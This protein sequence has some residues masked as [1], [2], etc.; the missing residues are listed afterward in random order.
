MGTRCRESYL[1]VYCIGGVL[2]LTHTLLPED[3][4]A[5]A[6]RFQQLSQFLPEVLADFQVELVQHPEAG[7]AVA[8][9]YGFLVAAAWVSSAIYMALLVKLSS[10]AKFTYLDTIL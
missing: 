2:V 3:S 5:N 4:H 8:Q 6:F 10:M 7:K 9:D 1:G